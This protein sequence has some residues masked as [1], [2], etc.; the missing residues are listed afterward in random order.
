MVVVPV[1]EP[2]DARPLSWLKLDRVVVADNML[3]I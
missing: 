2:T 1:V 3:L